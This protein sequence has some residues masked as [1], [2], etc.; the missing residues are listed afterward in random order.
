MTETSQKPT[1][2]GIAAVLL[3]ALGVLSLMGVGMLWPMFILVPG[4]MMLGIAFAGGRAGAAAMSIPGMLVTGTG[5]LMFV[6]NL[7]GHWESWA[8]AWTLYGVFLGMGFM[9][10]AQRLGDPSLH[11]VGRG[12]VNISLLV[13]AGLAFMFEIIFGIGRYGGMNALLLIGLG[14]FLLTRGPVCNRIKARIGE[15]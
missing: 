6:Q 13:F 14:L 4:L 7:T 1:G 5:A 9:L 2:L 8:Y 11:R 12:F 3:I 10:M 15:S